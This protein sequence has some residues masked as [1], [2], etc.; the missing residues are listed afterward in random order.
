[1]SIDRSLHVKSGAAR[2]RSVLKRPERIVVM[3]ENGTFDD[4][5]SKV[6]GLPK[7]RVKHSKAGHKAKKEEVAE[8]TAAT[9]AAAPAGGKAAA[10]KPAAGA[11]KGK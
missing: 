3:S 5:T 4:E 10:A 6:L 7:T 9:P 2:K 8:G 11:K 1:M